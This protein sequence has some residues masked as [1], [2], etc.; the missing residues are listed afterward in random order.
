M[1]TPTRE[2]DREQLFRMLR[3]AKDAERSAASERA[4]ADKAVIESF[5]G[6]VAAFADL[7]KTYRNNGL[8]RSSVKRAMRE[9]CET[10]A[11]DVLR[12][13]KPRVGECALCRTR[14][15]AGVVQGYCSDACRHAAAG[16][17]GAE[18]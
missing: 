12:A 1:K 3:R 15:A 10:L 4:S 2:E 17:K 18:G 5:G 9:L 13:K 6:D 7:V 8:D 16:A 14:L 11:P